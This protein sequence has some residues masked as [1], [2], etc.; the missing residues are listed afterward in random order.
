MERRDD[1]A[2]HDARQ[3]IPHRRQHNLG[4]Q[5]AAEIRLLSDQP[6]HADRGE[7][8]INWIRSLSFD[9]RTLPQRED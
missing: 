2:R 3:K 8:L 7:A 1:V 9:D 4:R 5:C 6:P